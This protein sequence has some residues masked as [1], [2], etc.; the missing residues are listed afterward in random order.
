MK[1]DKYILKYWRY[2]PIAGTIEF[3]TKPMTLKEIN[4]RIESGHWSYD[5]HEIIEV[6]DEQSVPS[7]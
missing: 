6:S 3:Q 2:N 7:K 1:A 4:D 5:R